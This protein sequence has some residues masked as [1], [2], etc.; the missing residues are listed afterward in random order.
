MRIQIV[1]E[2]DEVIGY[3]DRK[4]D[5]PK[6]ITRISAL[7]ITDKYRN[8]LLA[9]RAFTKKY[10]PGVWGPAVAGTVEEEETYESNIIKEAEE[11]IG[12]VG[13]KPVL[14][15]KTRVSSAHEYFCQWFTIVVNS[16]YP[17]KKKDD[18]VEKIRWFTRKEIG[19]LIKEEQEM[20]S[21]NFEHY[22][23][24]FK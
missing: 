18:E 1:N 23:N 12:L 14:G 6:N 21:G 5:N 8:I 16:D 9:Q 2:Q 4:N 10:S 20:F 17:F 11:E 3:E 7:W 19:K 22:F 15:P 13:F 24:L